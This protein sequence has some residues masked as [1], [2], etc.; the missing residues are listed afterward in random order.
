[1]AIQTLQAINSTLGLNRNTMKSALFTTIF[2]IA[3]IVNVSGQEQQNKVFKKLTSADSVILVSH[4]TTNIPIVDSTTKKWIGSVKLVDKNKPNYK[5]IRESVRLNRN[6]IDSV[7]TILITANKD[8]I[9]EDIQCF[10]PHHGMLIFKKGKCSYFDICFDCRHFITSKD[11]ELSDELSAKTWND[12]E[13]FF[14]NR[15]LNYEMPGSE[16]G[17]EEDN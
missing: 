15:N 12:L 3:N 4:L 1:M 8:T 7:A 11:F 16:P 13:S 6:D 5:I 14:R 2:F 17:T 10:I 9:I